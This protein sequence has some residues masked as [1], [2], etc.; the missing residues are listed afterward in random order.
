MPIIPRFELSQTKTDIILKICVPH[1]RVSPEQVQ[2]VLTDDF[3]VLHFASPPYL[4]VLNFAAVQGRFHETAEEACAKY[5]P[6]I[7]NGIISLQLRKEVPNIMWENLDLLGRMTTSSSQ[8]KAGAGA[9]WLQSVEDESVPAAVCDDDDDATSEGRGYGFLRL[10]H[11]VYTDLQHDGLAKEMLE[12][13]WEEQTESNLNSLVLKDRTPQEIRTERRR[14]RREL[15][16]EKFCSERYLGDLDLEE[17]YVY[18]CAMALSPHWQSQCSVESL[19]EKLSSLQVQ[20]G[21]VTSFFTEEERTKLLSIPYPILPQRLSSQKEYALLVGLLDILFA[22]VYDHLITDGD[23]TVES[24]WTV[25]ILSA[26]LSSLDDWLDDEGSSEEE[27]VRDALSTCL[28]RAVT[29]PYLRN[30]DFGIHVWKQVLNLIRQGVRP[31]LRSLLQTRAIL[32]CSELYYMGC[33]IFLDP[34][35]AWLQASP[36][37]IQVTLSRLCKTMDCILEQSD[38][39]KAE[40][41]LELFAI[42]DRACAGF[43][44]DNDSSRDSSS[45]SASDYNDDDNDEDDS[46]ESSCSSEGDKGPFTESGDTYTP[47]VHEQT[48]TSSRSSSLLDHNLGPENRVALSLAQDRD[49]ATTMGNRPLIQ[50]IDSCIQDS[51][52]G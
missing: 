35:L 48:E 25:S 50:E 33:K 9:R 8:N 6:T 41:G 16:A 49:H 11:G 52:H 3:T 12:M 46:E 45:E 24:A 2:V 27:L 7:E 13:P 30:F 31:I 15:E 29:Y 32:D 18:Q 21:I 22:Y 20:D 5:D 34:Y 26:S 38:S 44:D 1:V 23:P 39:L 14:K 43:S 42:E 47:P 19:S 37:S 10:F 28:R 40:L 36:N 51:C 4:L 17:D